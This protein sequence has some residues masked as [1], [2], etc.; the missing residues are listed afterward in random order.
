M[1]LSR[2]SRQGGKAMVKATID[3]YNAVVGGLLPTPVKSHY[4]FN[5][6]D[7]SKVMQG[8]LTPILIPILIHRFPNVLQPREHMTLLE[9]S[10]V[11]L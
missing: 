2:R 1:W 5:L 10:W 4:T 9:Q 8:T 11:C 6:R 3:T 7:V